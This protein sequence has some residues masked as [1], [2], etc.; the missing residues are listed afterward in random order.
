MRLDVAVVGSAKGVDRVKIGVV[1]DTHGD[2]A[3]WEKAWDVVLRDCDFIF[4]CGDI[5]YHGPK[6]DPGPGHGPREIAA[7]LNSLAV[8]LL[9]AR[10][11]GDS[12]VDSLVIEAP[13]QS[14]YALAQIEG[15]RFLATHGHLQSPDELLSLAAR[16]G[17]DYLLTG[18]THV[19]LV[20]VVEG[21]T[22]LNPGT[23]TYPLAKDDAL[24]VPSCAVIADDSVTVV[25][26]DTG[27]P[28]PLL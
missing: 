8:P 26:L 28:V 15:T 12:D 25:N 11:N 18:H 1:S 23:T 9:L 5:L 20:R 21:V 4:H 16:W 3:A 7:A 22:H 10:G 27:E 19:P 2:F 24:C 6:F 13:I 14:P 17:V